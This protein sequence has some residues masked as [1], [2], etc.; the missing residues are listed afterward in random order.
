MKFQFYRLY[1]LLILSSA[2]IIWSF[3]EIHGAMQHQ[4][5]SY[6]IDVDSVFR[7]LSEE[8]SSVLFRQLSR[9]ELAL[10][11]DLA[12]KLDGGE[13]IALTLSGGKT[14]YYRQAPD[15]SDPNN[16][17]PA[18]VIAFGPVLRKPTQAV[19]TEL[20]IFA[21]YASLGCLALLLIWPLFRDLSQ[22]QA[23][24]VEFGANPRKMEQ[25]INKRSAIY[26]LAKVFH[27]VTVQIVDFL[28]MHKEL[29]RTI[30]HE[31][32]TP[33][34]RMRFALQ[35]SK[36]ELDEKYWQRLNA[37][38]DEIEQLAN[39]YLSFAK[40]EHRE[41]QIKKEAV[42]T[43]AFLDELEEKFALY[44][45]KIG[46]TFIADDRLAV[47]D[48]SSMSI[49]TQN[50]IMNALRFAK[51]NIQ[52]RFRC[53]D[54]LCR[55]TVED[56]G[57]GFEGKGKQLLAAFARDKEQSDGSGY[58]L[59]LYIARKIA[60]WHQGRLEVAKSEELGGASLT[61]VWRNQPAK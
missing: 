5:E 55:I 23:S 11:Q 21:L 46:I 52:V 20:I 19:P 32:R 28:Q 37:D 59:G 10:P 30:S 40:L 60:I 31:V 8:D 18:K 39:N 3:S 2:L 61:L 15:I 49:A 33:L 1:A 45:D 35:L 42:S 14:Y 43:Q 13:T 4:V 47:F 34:A 50:L 12:D 38:I 54:D 25:T 9:D 27:E 7:G 41:A 36:A 58:G 6:Q 57:P 56:D 51:Q 16:K 22:L 44:Q 53:E 26:P 24:A 17:E 48:A 29:S